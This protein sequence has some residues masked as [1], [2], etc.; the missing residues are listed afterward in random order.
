[1]SDELRSLAMHITNLAIVLDPEV[2]S[3]GGGLLRSADRIVPVIRQSA[4][5]CVPFPPMVTVATFADDG[6]LV[7]AAA[8]A[9]GSLTVDAT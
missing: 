8:A 5:R 2:V 3:L 4:D 7:G 9:F 1:L 6:P